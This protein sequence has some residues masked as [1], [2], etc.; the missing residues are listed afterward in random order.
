MGQSASTSSS[1]V[2]LLDPNELYK[3]RPPAFGHAM[4]KYF[5]FDAEFLNLNH[6]TNIQSSD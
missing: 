4:R 5:A 1:A 3:T 6:G 2:S